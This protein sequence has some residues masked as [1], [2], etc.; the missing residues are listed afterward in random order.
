MIKIKQTLDQL[1][2]ELDH[3]VNQDQV[4]E[5]TYFKVKSIKVTWDNN[6]HSFMHVFVNTTKVK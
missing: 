2:G 4:C 6:N 1:Q 3:I 5:E